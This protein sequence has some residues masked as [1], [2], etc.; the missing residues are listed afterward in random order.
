MVFNGNAGN[1]THEWL[2]T[3]R[4]D[5]NLSD[6]DHLFG[7]AKIDKGLQATYTNVLNPVFNADSP[8]PQYEGQLGET[9]TF[10][11]EP[12]QPVSVCGDLLSRHLY[13]HEP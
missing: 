8:Q 4:I 13:Q 7:H 3:A 2:M 11:P 1:F 6:K 12:D 9:H 10:L 5:Q